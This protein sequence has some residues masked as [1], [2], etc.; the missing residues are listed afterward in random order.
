[1]RPNLKPHYWACWK[2]VLRW[3]RAW[4]L[5]S[6]AH[7]GIVGV[8]EGYGNTLWARCYLYTMTLYFGSSRQW[9]DVS[10]DHQGKS[11]A[12]S[13]EGCVGLEASPPPIVSHG[14]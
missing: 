5:F 10:F 9:I 1:M 8:L 4:P 11:E 7:R 14:S 12:Q 6:T 3:K 2:G 13:A